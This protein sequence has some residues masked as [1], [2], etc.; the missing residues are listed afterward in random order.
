MPTTD[1]PEEFRRQWYSQ[2]ESL[3]SLL[4]TVPPTEE[5]RE[6]LEEAQDNLK[7]LVEEGVK[8]MEEDNE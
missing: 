2:I 5:N 7:D 8:A 3:R 4:H 1:D 6:K